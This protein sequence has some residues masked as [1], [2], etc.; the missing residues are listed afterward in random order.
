MMAGVVSA[1]DAADFPERQ[2]IEE[3]MPVKP[4]LAH[5]ELV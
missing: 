4:Y 1:N 3:F 5:E 2:L